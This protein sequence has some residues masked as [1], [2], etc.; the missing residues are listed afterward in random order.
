MRILFLC[1]QY[2]IQHTPRRLVGQCPELR[3][4][5]HRWVRALASQRGAAGD[6]LFDMRRHDLR[7]IVRQYPG[8]EPDLMIVWEPGYVP[9][10][11][12]IEEAP[13]PVVACYSDWNLV[14]PHQAETLELYD[15]IFTDRPGVG[16]LNRMG[17]QNVEFWP[18]WGHDPNASRLIP[19][20][21]KDWDIGMIGNLNADV[22]RE[23]APWLARVARL[24]N[25]Y[26][27]R[28]AGGV[29]GDA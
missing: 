26:R 3:N 8:G 24:A 2:H 17:H 27:I 11:R 21:P 4:E 13:F 7:D 10:P 20:V 12:G 14:Q 15:H 5:P 16:I 25:R 22:Q 18:M 19:D 29:Y 6:I 28:I 23:R 1:K 9:L